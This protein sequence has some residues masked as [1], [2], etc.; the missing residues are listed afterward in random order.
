MSVLD[1]VRALKDQ[2]RNSLAPAK[3]GEHR[4][5]FSTLPGILAALAAFITAMVSLVQSC[6]SAN[7]AVLERMDK[8][9]ETCQVVTAAERAERDKQ[10]REL[11]EKNQALR[12]ENQRTREL[13]FEYYRKLE[14][15]VYDLEPGPLG[16]K[17][18]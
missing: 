2:A 10:V 3:P 4:G 17:K 7:K 13:A 14:S 16:H 8:V 15:R 6:N 12:E 11:I 18:K 9:S 5:F 1:N